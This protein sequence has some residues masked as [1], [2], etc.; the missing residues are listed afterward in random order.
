MN[1][2]LLFFL[3][4]PVF[5]IGQVQIGQ[6]IDGVPGDLSGSHVSLSSDG[7]IVAIG[8][9]DG[10]VYGIVSGLVRVYGNISGVWTQI[11]QLIS[12]KAYGDKFG[13]SISLSA[14][15][16]IVAIGAPS[17]SYAGYGYVSVYKNI[18]G[19]WTQIGQDIIG[20]D[21][22]VR[23]GVSVSLSADGNIVAI[24]APSNSYAGYVSVYKNISGVWTQIG[25]I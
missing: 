8:A 12:G 6:D 1:V 15:G 2:K 20:N 13:H 22:G 4:F 11:D 19:V 5:G 16:N 25:Q 14:D 9:P 10:D 21:F 18:S 17:N 3:L 7:N 24:G 23:K